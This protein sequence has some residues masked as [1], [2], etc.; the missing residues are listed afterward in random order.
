MKL[1][2]REIYTRDILIDTGVSTVI[3]NEEY[4]RV[5]LRVEECG[6]LIE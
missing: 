4:V 2:T 5:A 1:G 6:S 3:L